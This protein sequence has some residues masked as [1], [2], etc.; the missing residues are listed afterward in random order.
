MKQTLVIGSTVV[1]VVLSLP[2]LPRRGEDINIGP[3]V[4]RLGGCAYNVFKTL[5]LFQSPAQLCSPVGS[6]IYGR[7]VEEG[8][9]R[10]GIE[11]FV[12]LEA[13]NGCCYCLVEADGERSFL[14]WHGAE[15][16]FSRS[17]M[18]KP[19]YSRI[20]S[21][22]ICGIE[23]EEPSGDELV[24]FVLE[25][26]ELDLY[27]APGPRITRIPRRRVERLLAR[28][29]ANGGPFL[30]LNEAEAAAFSG[31]N[32]VATAAEVLAKMT[33]NGLVITLGERGC[34]CR[35]KDADAG[36]FVPGAAARVIDTVGAGDAHCG[37]LIAGFKQGRGLR[38]A[39]GIAN[40]IGAAVV[41][42]HGTTPDSLP[43]E[44]SPL[45]LPG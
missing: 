40:K 5:R 35:E 14:S 17:W 24:E 34:Y 30:H 29:G 18:K 45:P 42:M 10:E 6:G 25:H 7:M 13:E 12:R 44:D 28:R 3:S 21:V 33:G 16:L 26:P 38:E 15:Y 1:D 19:D 23:V 9:A 31:K 43:G 41:G 20:D 4:C 8:L 36:F 39:C 32:D 2:R 22:F 11:P 37:A 27:F